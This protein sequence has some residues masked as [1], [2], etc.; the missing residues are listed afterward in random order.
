MALAARST[1]EYQPGG[2][3]ISLV[4]ES[5][6]TIFDG[7]LV[8]VAKSGGGG[9][10]GYVTNWTD[11]TDSLIFIGIARI[12]DQNSGTG[13]GDSVTGD[14]TL[15]IEC[16]ISGPILKNATVTGLD[17]VNDVMDPV[18]ASDSNTLTLTATTGSNE[19]GFVTRYSGTSGTGD[20]HLFPFT[21]FASHLIS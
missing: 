16:D 8:G 19:I 12:T 2:L 3:K 1:Q 14:G 4:V 15:E 21:A 6:T 5:G 18:Y 10:D 9:S 17:N 11:G 20:V 13:T 7:A